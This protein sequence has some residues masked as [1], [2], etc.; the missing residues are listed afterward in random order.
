MSNEN[1]LHHCQGITLRG[2]G[3]R[4][5]INNKSTFCNSHDYKTD[6]CS[7]CLSNKNLHKLN[8]CTH[9]FCKEC[10]KEIFKCPLCRKMIKITNKDLEKILTCEVI[11]LTT[12]EIQIKMLETH[13][14]NLETYKLLYRGMLMELRKISLLIYNNYYR[15]KFKNFFQE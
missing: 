11:V 9:Y 15:H 12:K 7:V 3:C 1:N 5:R 2:V 4:R 14:E 13:V 8:C 6:E 10:N